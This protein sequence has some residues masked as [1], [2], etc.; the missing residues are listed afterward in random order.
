MVHSKTT[1]CSLQIND[2]DCELVS[3][4]S[5]ENLTLTANCCNISVDSYYD[6]WGEENYYLTTFMKNLKTWNYVE[7]VKECQ[8]ESFAFTAYSELI[9]LKFCNQSKFEQRCTDSLRSVAKRQLGKDITF[10]WEEG[11]DKLNLHALTN[12]EILDPC[13]QAAMY[14]EDDNSDRFHEIISIVPFCDV[15]WCGFDR[16][17]FETKSIS[18]WTCMSQR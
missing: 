7:F 2:F 18:S 12:K 3:C 17:I 11:A 14:D 8:R 4:T 9:Y 5:D 13:I 15:T 1:P 6:L 16:I 10:S